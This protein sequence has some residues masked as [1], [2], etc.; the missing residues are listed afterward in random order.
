MDAGRQS[1]AEFVWWAERRRGRAD[2]RWLSVLTSVPRRKSPNKQSVRHDNTAN[3]S[4]FREKGRRDGV[5][6]QRARRREDEMTEGYGG[7][8]DEGVYRAQRTR[9]AGGGRQGS[10]V[11]SVCLWC[12]AGR[13][14][15]LPSLAPCSASSSSTLRLAPS[16]QPPASIHL[17][18]RGYALDAL[19][20]RVD[21]SYR[22][23]WPC[24]DVSLRFLIRQR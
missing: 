16:A 22:L 20:G 12:R 18:V 1:V 7:V 17:H 19:R 6:E 24:I 15:Q 3:G 11:S 10:R 9:G 4:K 21:M 8:E 14:L 5:A 2:S 23:T 13:A